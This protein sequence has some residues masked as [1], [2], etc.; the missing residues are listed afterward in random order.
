MAL[1]DGIGRESVNDL[2]LFETWCMETAGWI[3]GEP[4]KSINSHFPDDEMPKP[5][6]MALNAI[7]TGVSVRL[8][9]A[10]KSE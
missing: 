2:L 8:A 9:D 4:V 5:L 3:A 7:F 6:A 10:E 1:S